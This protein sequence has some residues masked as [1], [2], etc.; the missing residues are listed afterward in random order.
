MGPDG[1]NGERDAASPGVIDRLGNKGIAAIAFGL[2][3]ALV[4]FTSLGGSDDPDPPPATTLL[5]AAPT[6]TEPDR[7]QVPP[8]DSCTL[9]PDRDLESAMG[10]VDEDG[11][12]RAGGYTAFGIREACR[13][14]ATLE[15]TGETVAIELGPGEQDD[16]APDHE[17]L[18]V[19]AVPAEGVGDLAV[20]YPGDGTGT[21]SAIE[22]TP[23]GILFVRL[24]LERSEIDDTSRRAIAAELVNTAI[25]R[26]RFGPPP[27]VEADLCELI[28]DDDAERF[29]G[30]HREGR[31]G[32]RDEVFGGGSPKVVDLSESG[33]TFC[34]KLITTEIY[35]TASMSSESDF[36]GSARVDGIVGE[37]VPG[38]GDQAVWFADVPGTGSFA[39]AHDTGILAV[40]RDAAMFRI[41]VALPDLDSESRQ[42]AA[43]QLALAALNRLPGADRLVVLER[44]ETPDLSSLGFVHNLLE[45]VDDGEWTIGEGLVAT[46]Q[47]FAGGTGAADVLRSDDLVDTSGTEIMRMAR[48]YAEDGPDDAVRQELERLL[49]VLGLPTVQTSEEASGEAG[50]RSVVPVS[51]AGSALRTAFPVRNLA[52]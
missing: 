24:T 49:E 32:A 8:I 42:D 50:A 10:L 33:D 13:W 51:L 7:P 30:P 41:V 52:V 22:R 21:M 45:R 9:L 34:Q 23:N 35:V 28:S 18:S 29:L 26:I 25:D 43:V 40:R 36:D 27:P 46:L 3:A 2:V 19:T 12:R 39:S 6:T 14:E 20:W 17:M 5:A 37:E 48:V 16:F 1:M 31:P 15:D 38:V 11:S 4:L 47:L 44:L